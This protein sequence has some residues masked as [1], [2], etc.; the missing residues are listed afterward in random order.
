MWPLFQPPRP[1][2]GVLELPGPAL[3][4]GGPGWGP[5][6][7]NGGQGGQRDGAGLGTETAVP[8]E[9]GTPG[10]PALSRSRRVPRAGY[11]GA[12]VASPTPTPP[13]PSGG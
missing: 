3:R 9:L 8:T 10:A 4:S 5:R 7:G 2:P 12:H 1:P 11:P 6:A 13:A